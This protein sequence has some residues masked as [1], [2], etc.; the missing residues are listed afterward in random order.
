VVCAFGITLLAL[1]VYAKL[2]GRRSGL[3][4]PDA[5]RAASLAAGRHEGD[6]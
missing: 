1:G 4:G 5:L 2:V 3:V 6:A